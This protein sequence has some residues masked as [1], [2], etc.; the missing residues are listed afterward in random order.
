MFFPTTKESHI[1]KT[2]SG[3]FLIWSY[4]HLYDVRIY[5][6]IDTYVYTYVY[7]YIYIYMYMYTR[8]YIYICIYVYKYPRCISIALRQPFR[9]MAAAGSFGH[10]L[11]GS[12]STGSRST[13]ARSSN[14]G[15]QKWRVWSPNHHVLPTE[16]LFEH[17]WYWDY[18]FSYLV[19]LICFY[20]FGWP[21]WNWSW[22]TREDHRRKF[23]S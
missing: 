9:S 1:V 3:S 10:P 4:L 6:Y 15:A 13:A 11:G 14:S 19:L 21:H 16:S 22:D 8:C 7:L 5:L 2:S 20:H 18:W 17:V 12:K 23:R